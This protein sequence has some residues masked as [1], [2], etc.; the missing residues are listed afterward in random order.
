MCL[1]VSDDGSCGRS[2]RGRGWSGG[3]SGGKGEVKGKREEQED[4]VEKGEEE[5]RRGRQKGEMEGRESGGDG[6]QILKNII[7]LTTSRDRDSRASSRAWRSEPLLIREKAGAL[8]K[9]SEQL[10]T[11]PWRKGQGKFT[12]SNRFETYHPSPV[13]NPLICVD[14]SRKARAIRVKQHA[15]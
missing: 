2:L 4:G 11:L 10:T 1:R 3:R 12:L 5:R 9:I 13:L 15:I 8:W 6:C 14:K 7:L